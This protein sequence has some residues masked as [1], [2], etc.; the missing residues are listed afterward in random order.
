MRFL[1]MYY[2]ISCIF[3]IFK[4]ENMQYFIMFSNI[5]IHLIKFYSYIS[6]QV[7]ATTNKSLKHK[8][9][10]SEA[11]RSFVLSCRTYLLKCLKG[12]ETR[13]SFFKALKS[14]KNNTFS[15]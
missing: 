14:L 8:V 13:H 9:S 10:M 7:F 12:L 15:V 4:S 11:M 6:F 1:I 5:K 2:E 3:I